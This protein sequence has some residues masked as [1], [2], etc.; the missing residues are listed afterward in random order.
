M[1]DTREKLNEAKYF[2]NQM[3]EKQADR[4][5]FKYNLSAFLTAARSVTWFMQNEF[6]KKRGFKVWY[7]KKQTEMKNDEIMRF[8]NEKRVKTI[9]RKPI[10]PRVNVKVSMHD[11]IGLS[12][13]VSIIVTRPDG[14]I[15]SRQSKP[16][17]K[18]TPAKTENA[19]EW[20][21]YFDEMPK[22]DIV[23]VCK[24]HIVKLDTLAVDC[25]S[26]FS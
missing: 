2:L 11:R 7:A 17:K 5:G 16:A 21:M 22:K 9:H 20:G 4:D 19:V 13:S 6:G 26:K 25:E 1:S 15:M 18:P 12:S 24:E 10:D 8:L 23:T 3:I 14:T